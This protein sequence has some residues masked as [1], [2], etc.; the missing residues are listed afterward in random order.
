MQVVLTYFTP[1]SLVQECSPWL[2][3]SV[4]LLQLVLRRCTHAH[5]EIISRNTFAPVNDFTRGPWGLSLCTDVSFRLSEG[6]QRATQAPNGVDI[7][8]INCV[9]TRDHVSDNRASARP[10]AQTSNLSH[11]DSLLHSTCARKGHTQAGARTRRCTKGKVTRS[12]FLLWHST[13]SRANTT[14]AY[15]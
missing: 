13:A 3:F 15:L 1:A 11:E 8:S 5:E 9:S 12:S 2:P 4:S 14:P 10:N 7:C 6:L